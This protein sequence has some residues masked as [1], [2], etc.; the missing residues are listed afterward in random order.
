MNKYTLRKQ[1]KPGIL[2]CTEGVGGGTI[3]LCDFGH[4]SQHLIF[5]FVLVQCEF[6][7]GIN[8]ILNDTDLPENSGG[9]K[10]RRKKSQ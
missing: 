10:R 6:K 4:C 9:T 1:H 2:D 7:F 5:G 3:H 8:T